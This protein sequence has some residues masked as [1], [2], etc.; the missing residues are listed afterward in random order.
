M[1]I[2][3]RLSG[4]RQGERERHIDC[5]PER[6]P[7]MNSHPVVAVWL[8]PVFNALSAA[9]TPVDEAVAATITADG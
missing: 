9:K 1:F 7:E 2:G 3:G 8:T 6:H 5:P 4:S